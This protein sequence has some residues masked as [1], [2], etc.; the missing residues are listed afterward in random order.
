MKT[1]KFFAFAALVCGFAMSFTSC[2]NDDNPVNVK[3]TATISFE[4]ATL[5]ADGYWCGDE[6]GVKYDNWGH[7]LMQSRVWYSL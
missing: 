1:N 3:K 6:N 5:N 7:V 4:G 2:T